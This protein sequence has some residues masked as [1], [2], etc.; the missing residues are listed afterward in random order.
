MQWL[1]SK[2]KVATFLLAKSN[3]G[4]YGAFYCRQL[5]QNEVNIGKIHTYESSSSEFIKLL[6]DWQLRQQKPSTEMFEYSHFSIMKQF[7]QRNFSIKKKKSVLFLSQ[8]VSISSKIS[9]QISSKIS[10]MIEN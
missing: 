5:Q 8:I 3:T 7:M 2:Q 1:V 4:F 10:F 6:C 9:I